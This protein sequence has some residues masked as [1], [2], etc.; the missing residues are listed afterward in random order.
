[1]AKAKKS[2][3]TESPA[4]AKDSASAAAAKKKPAKG[5]APA[6]AAPT[7]PLIDTGLAAE[8]AAKM[9]GAKVAGPAGGQPAAAGGAKETSAFKN[10]KANLNKPASST[11]S[12]FLDKTAGPGQKKQNL[13]FGGG[14]QVGRNQTFGADVN[15]AGVPR[16][17]GGG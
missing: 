9:I 16:R 12:N 4:A 5:K 11:M 8:T 3:Q 6:T 7:T 15:R 14:K 17:T 10:L 1:M 13:P 2:E